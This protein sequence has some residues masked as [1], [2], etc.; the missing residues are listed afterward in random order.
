MTSKFYFFYSNQ[1]S[2][3]ENLNPVSRCIC[4]SIKIVTFATGGDREPF[5]RF[6]KHLQAANVAQ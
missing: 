5:Q 1:Q 3:D 6:K 2:T 4:N